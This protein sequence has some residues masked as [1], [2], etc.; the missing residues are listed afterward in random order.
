MST[1]EG[2]MSKD[3][4]VTREGAHHRQPK[5]VAIVDDLGDD[6]YHRFRSYLWWNFK[7]DLKLQS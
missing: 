7:N 1:R 4:L 3:W 6:Y 5:M 2:E